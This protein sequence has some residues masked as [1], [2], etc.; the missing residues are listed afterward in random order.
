MSSVKTFNNLD[1]VIFC[2]YSIIRIYEVSVHSKLSRKP[3]PLRTVTRADKFR[4]EFGIW[5]DLIIKASIFFG[6]SNMKN[7]KT[8]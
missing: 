1:Y 4:E 6:Y 5:E 3:Q 2:H 7:Q 8:M